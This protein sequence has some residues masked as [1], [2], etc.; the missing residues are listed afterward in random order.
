MKETNTTSYR[1]K[2]SLWN[3]KKLNKKILYNHYL[4]C[5]KN[6]RDTSWFNE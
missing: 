4:W 6:N 1:Y 2:R 5:K 3:R